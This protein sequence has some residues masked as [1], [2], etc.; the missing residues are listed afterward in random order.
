MKNEA[1][2]NVV[3][4]KTEILSFNKLKCQSTGAIFN[5]EKIKNNKIPSHFFASPD[6]KTIEI[7]G[8]K[9]K[10]MRN[11]THTEYVAFQIDG[12]AYYVR[13]HKF[14]D[15][16]K[17]TTYEKPKA[18]KKPASLTKAALLALLAAN[19]IEIPAS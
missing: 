14:I 7:N 9:F 13:S 10:A 16:V 12:Q 17:Y 4:I 18:D 5:V 8:Q 3:E 15:Q 1:K 2:K 6:F 19:N 11:V